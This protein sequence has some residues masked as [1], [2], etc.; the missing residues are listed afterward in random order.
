MGYSTV[1]RY[2]GLWEYCR[3]RPRPMSGKAD[4]VAQKAFKQFVRPLIQDPHV[5]LWFCDETGIEANPRPYVVWAPKGSKP[6]IPYIGD[7][8]RQ[9]VMGAV[10]PA[11]GRFF[12]LIVTLSNTELFQVFLDQLNKE[13]N[14][15]QQ[16]I[17]ILDNV[18][19]H[20]TKGL[21]WGKL[22]PLYLPPYSPILNPAEEIWLGTKKN[23][24]YH[25]NPGSEFEHENRT[26]TALNYYGNNPEL[27]MSICATTTYFRE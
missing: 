21:R 8:W 7:H 12:S 16:N 5:D 13:L 19:F 26:V 14:P 27:V 9:N 4:P 17:L 23:F 11:D 1:C 15:D 20:K 3:L 24:F 6:T 25:W 10:C 2:L 18:S 22:Q